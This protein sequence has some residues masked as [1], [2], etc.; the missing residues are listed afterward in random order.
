MTNIHATYDY[1]NGLKL[2]I[3]DFKIVDRRNYL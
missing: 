3:S 2:V 1:S